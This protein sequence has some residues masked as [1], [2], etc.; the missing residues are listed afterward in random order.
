[1]NQLTATLRDD[2]ASP[3]SVEAEFTDEF[4]REF[5]ALERQTAQMPKLIVGIFLGIAVLTLVITAVWAV[6]TR[7]LLSREASASGRVVDYT[8]RR[9]EDG[10]RTAFPI[11][12][13]SLPDESVETVQLGEGSWPPAYDKNEAVA[14]RYDSADPRT[15]R[16][17]SPDGAVLLWLGPTITGFV[18]LAF[19]GAAIF[20][21]RFLLS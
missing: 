12:A 6:S 19:F 20:A 5:A 15:A 17:D 9:D 10:Q 13:F 11:V 16:I 4:D 21:Y 3:P 1:M 7:M 18:S 2:V 8:V 14:I